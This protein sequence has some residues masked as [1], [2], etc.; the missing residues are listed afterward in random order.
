[1][2]REAE[3]RLERERQKAAATPGTANL[4]PVVTPP[5]AP[6]PLMGLRLQRPKTGFNALKL[7][8]VRQDG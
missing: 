4:L 6:G 1:M 2:R 7:S 5:P 3:E 8:G